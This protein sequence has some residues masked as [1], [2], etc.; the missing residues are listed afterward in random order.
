MEPVGHPHPLAD[1][2]ARPRRRPQ[3]RIHR[4][5][6]LL[7]SWAAGPYDQLVDSRFEPL[8]FAAR[9]LAPFGYALLAFSLGLAVGALTRKT[10]VAM[11]ATLVAFLAFGLLMANVVRPHFDQPVTKTI[12]WAEANTVGTIDTFGV[13]SNGARIQGYTITG[14]WVLDEEIIVYDGT[15]SA[16]TREQ[17]RA[18]DDNGQNPDECMI[19]IDASFTVH[20]QPA[21]R[22][23]TFQWLEA[24][25][26]A[27]LSALLIGIAYWRIPR[28]L[29]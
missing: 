13:G 28:G 21:D 22:Y 29:N 23:W 2:Q 14:A 4:G 1:G 25:T 27:A 8:T 24:G 16:V 5:L 7:L 20:Y 18:C 17:A 10:L 26:A 12:D 11:A 19:A 3:R 15:G 6:G 9:H